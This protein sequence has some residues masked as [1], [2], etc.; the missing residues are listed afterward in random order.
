[1]A[2]IEEQLKNIAKQMGNVKISNG[3]DV[4][5]FL[6]QEGERLKKYIEE[7]IAIYKTSYTPKIYIR[8]GNWENSMEL[9]NPY[10]DG[11][12]MIIE[13]RFNPVLANHPSVIHPEDESQQGYVPWLMEVGW[14][15]HKPHK[16]IP[17][18]TDFEG[19]QYIKKAVERYNANNPYGFKIKV[20]HDNKQYI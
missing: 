9:G 11:N 8:T 2:S 15:W 17:R 5:K 19:T 7:E 10:Q 16:V 1:M 18:F 14:H 3:F 12:N 4:S 20:Y 13:I 6:K